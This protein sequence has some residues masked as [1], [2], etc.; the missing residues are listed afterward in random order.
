MGLKIGIT[1]GIGSGKT[2]VCKIFETYG[3]PIYYADDRA[4]LLMVNN[5][6]VIQEIK[7]VFGKEAYFGDGNLNRK[8]IGAVAF[9]DQSKLKALNEIVHPAVKKDGELWQLDHS[10][11]PY[12]IKEAALLFESGNFAT[13]DKIITVV[14]PLELRI[15][16]VM[17][18]DKSS[19][20]QVQ[21]RIN[22]QWNDEDKV[23]LSDFI[24]YNDH[25]NSLIKQINKI[26]NTLITV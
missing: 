14:S 12:T 15:E 6:E 5:V 18:R 10:K 20:E 2:T 3:I 4:K 16:R 9:Q 17:A 24:I 1:G 13:L 7:K 11:S 26:H 22:K 25:E 19:R 21:S 8:Y 23:K